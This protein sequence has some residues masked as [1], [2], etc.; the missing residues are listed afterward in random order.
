MAST[1]RSSSRCRRS[2]CCTSWPN[3]RGRAPPAPRSE[4]ASAASAR[5]ERAPGG[6]GRAQAREARRARHVG[7]TPFSFSKPARPW[8][9]LLAFMSLSEKVQYFAR[10]DVGRLRDHNEDNYLVD[11]K[12]SLAVVADG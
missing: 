7:G 6:R 1:S 4:H 11:K 8:A 2:A 12:L 10:T 3:R 5:S 9:S